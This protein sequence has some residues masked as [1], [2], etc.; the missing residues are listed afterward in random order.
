M[1]HEIREE[2]ERQMIPAAFSY[3]ARRNALLE[4]GKLEGILSDAPGFLH[5]FYLSFYFFFP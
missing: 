3:A 1:M 4:T 2:K 5:V